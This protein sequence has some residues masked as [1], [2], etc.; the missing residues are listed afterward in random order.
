MRIISGTHKGRK[1]NMSNNLSVRPTT[2][3]A[4]ERLFNILQNRYV[5][6]NKHALD[7]FAGSGN[8][9]YEFFSRGCSSVTSVEINKKCILFI[10]NQIKQLN[11]NINIIHE[12][13]TKFIRRNNEKYDFIFLDPPYKSKDYNKL[14]ELIIEKNII[15]KG[16]CLIIEH[17]KKTNFND[18]N[19]EQKKYGSVYFSIFSF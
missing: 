4:K 14:K 16:G 5:F 12:D 8:I 9:S 7:L 2:D 17:D 10:K 19:V 18:C 1:I 6:N 15:H 13:A 11:I 3:R